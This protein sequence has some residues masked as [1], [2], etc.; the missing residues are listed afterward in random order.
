MEGINPMT[1]LAL[2]ER[3]TMIRSLASLDMPIDYPFAQT[4]AYGR[5]PA[6]VPVDVAENAIRAQRV[7]DKVIDSYRHPLDAEQVGEYAA[8]A[9]VKVDPDKF[10]GD[11]LDIIRKG[12]SESPLLASTC[13]SHRLLA[14]GEGVFDPAGLTDGRCANAETI[15]HHCIRRPSDGLTDEER[16]RMY[17]A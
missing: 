14:D 16:A 13:A 7:W 3:P 9:H 8:L 5:V 2:D 1:R 17:D 12:W 10:T 15:C 11:A 4:I 6:R